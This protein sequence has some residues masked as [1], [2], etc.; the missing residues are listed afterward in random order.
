VS[1]SDLD[2]LFVSDRDGAPFFIR[3]GL[4]RAPGG[5]GSQAIVI[6]TK[7]VRD[8]HLVFMPG[9]RVVEIAPGEIEEY[10]AGK[11]DTRAGAGPPPPPKEFGSTR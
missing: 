6:E 11:R 1:A 5:D 3:Y 10:K 7:G 8:R 2:R 4:R 9:P